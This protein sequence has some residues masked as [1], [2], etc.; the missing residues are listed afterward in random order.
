MSSSIHLLFVFYAAF[1]SSFMPTS[2]LLL[3]CRSCLYASLLPYSPTI[4]IHL[5]AYSTVIG[6]HDGVLRA[7]GN[8]HV[9]IS[10]FSKSVGIVLHYMH[11]G[12]PSQDNL[13]IQRE[14][15][16][17]LGFGILAGHPGLRM[18]TFK[19]GTID[20]VYV[21]ADILDP[22]RATSQKIKDVRGIE[23]TCTFGFSDLIPMAAPMMRVRG[24]TIVRLPVPT[25][26]C[27]GLTCHKVV[28]QVPEPVSNYASRFSSRH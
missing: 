6:P 27:V 14:E 15:A 18:P 4:Q 5:K 2:I 28:C 17:M 10:T 9:L 22:S 23:S 19:I 12:D 3:L 24:S 1:Y 11:I 8:G 13:Y 21:T 16:E 7:E 26:Y 20:E 25:Q